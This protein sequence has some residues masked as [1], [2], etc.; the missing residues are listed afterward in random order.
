MEKWK[1]RAKAR[2]INVINEYKLEKQLWRWKKIYVEF[3]YRFYLKNVF[4]DF[5]LLR[6]A[7]LNNVLIVRWIRNN[8]GYLLF[9]LSDGVLVRIGIGA[10]HSD[11]VLVFLV[12]VDVFVVG[13][14]PLYELNF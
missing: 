3:K 2:S 12:L 8:F 7:A 5:V 11:P 13:T 14:T 10:G 4:E 1:N 9:P 6:L